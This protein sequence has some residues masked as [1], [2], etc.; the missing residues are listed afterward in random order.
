MGSDMLAL[1]NVFKGAREPMAN[2][3]GDGHAELMARIAE[4]ADREAFATLFAYYAP[5]IKAM[6]LKA[7]ADAGLADDLAQDAMLTVWRKAALYSP[8]KGA[9][10]TWIFTIARNLRID[11]LRRQSSQPHRDVETIEI[12]S[13]APSGEAT[14]DERTVAEHVSAALALLPEEQRRVIEL[15]YIDDMAH[16]RIAEVLGI[17]VGTVKSRLRLAYEKLR[18]ELEVLR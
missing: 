11:R 5:R 6:M 15:S 7:G 13:D 14:A 3:L 1:N 18:G 10:S 8:G 4:T 9:V 17:P 2:E 16:G 12:A